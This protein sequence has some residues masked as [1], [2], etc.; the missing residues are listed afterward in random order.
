MTR[1]KLIKEYHQICSIHKGKS[2]LSDLTDHELFIFIAADT[3]AY[4][5]TL[6]G[7][8][9]N[10]TYHMKNRSRAEKLFGTKINDY[11]I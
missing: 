3:L 9:D 10:A 1:D 5:R 7:S 8:I 6:E 4:G 11:L 2:L